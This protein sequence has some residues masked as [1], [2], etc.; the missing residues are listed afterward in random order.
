VLKILHNWYRHCLNIIYPLKCVVCSSPIPTS[1][2]KSEFLCD[3]CFKKIKFISSPIYE[4]GGSLSSSQI[5]SP[6]NKKNELCFEKVFSVAVYEG[7]W[8]ELI[9]IFK[10]KRYD[11]I[12]KFFAGL[13]AELVLGNLSLK[14]SDFI[15]PVPLHWQDR[16]R[17]G[18]NQTELL[19]LQ[20][21]KLTSIPVFPKILI[22]GRKTPSQTALSQS[23]RIKNVK[24]AFMLKNSERIKNKKVILVDDVFTTGSTVN[25]CSKVLQEAKAGQVNV[26]TLA[27]NY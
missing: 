11:C 26:V 10:Y 15:V 17:R 14:M 27:Y 16:L 19:A 5:Y 4:K 21:S 12:D 20:L 2:F 24:D 18:Y 1:D 6:Y 3:A 23:Q 22:K 13:L 9:H 7:V 25:E 8:K